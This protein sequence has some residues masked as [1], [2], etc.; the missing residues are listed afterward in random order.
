[1][2]TMIE[3]IPIMI[4]HMIHPSKI[5]VRIEKKSSLIQSNMILILS[6]ELGS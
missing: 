4:A 1:M 6:I 5:H 2:S 3:I